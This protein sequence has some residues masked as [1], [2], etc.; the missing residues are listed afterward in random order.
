MAVSR[1]AQYVALYRALETTVRGR[2][3][4]FHDPFAKRFLARRYALLVAATSYSRRARRAL[5]RYADSRAPG[6]RTSAIARTAFLDDVV[7]EAVARGVRQLVILGAGFD[8]RAHRLPEL[9]AVRVF[10][11]DRADTQAVK[12]EVLAVERAVQYVA[13]DFQ[14][15][16]VATSLVAAGWD[17]EQPTCFLWEGVTNYLVEEAVTQVLAWIGS[18]APGSTLAFTY[19]HRGVL[20]G[21]VAFPGAD[22]LVSNVRGLGEPWTFGIHPDELRAFVARA[23]LVVRENLGADE[24]RRRYLGDGDHAGYAFYRIAVADVPLRSPS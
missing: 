14:K 4:L 9:M 21:S 18:T 24:Y 5:E 6:A 7:R 19:I 15:D 22:K 13:V 10:E 12:R 16:D 23:G 2:A 1:T 20:D 8:C 17:P 11:V 3:P